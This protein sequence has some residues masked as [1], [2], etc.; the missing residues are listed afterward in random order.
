MVSMA[1][2]E[3]PYNFTSVSLASEAANIS[4]PL[5]AGT[6][7]KRDSRNMP[8]FYSVR[9]GKEPGIYHSW[10]ECLNQVRG[11]PKAVFKSF[12]TLSEAQEFMN[13]QTTNTGKGTGNGNVYYAVRSGRQPGVYTDWSD[14]LAQITGWRGPKH[15]KF[16]TR[17]EAEQWVSEGPN[18]GYPIEDVAIGSIEEPAA[19][20]LKSNKPKKN[21]AIKDEAS[22]TMDFWDYDPGEGPL[23]EDAEDD[24]D[25]TIILDPTTGKLRYKTDEEQQKLKFKAT[26]LTKDGEVKIYTDGSSL[27]NGTAGAVAGVG[28]YFGAGDKRNVSEALPG[29]RQT[30]QRA[31]LTAILRALELAPRD[32]KALIISDSNYAINCVTVW[33]QKWRSNNWQNSSGKPVENKELIQQILVKLEDR[34]RMNR[35]RIDGGEDGVEDDAKWERGPASVKFKWVKG[36]DKDEGNNAADRLAVAGARE[37]KEMGGDVE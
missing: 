4:P 26:Y 17:R 29:T 18:T 6:K 5:S 25:S 28:V 3:R 13:S 23:P 31:E 20:K 19:K 33:F 2:I 12:E 8:K 36:H 32:R 7:R 35:H 27:G 16:K 15:R 34:H 22:A 30:N 24:F 21:N 1:D 37:A 10:K 9:V 11:F 14:V